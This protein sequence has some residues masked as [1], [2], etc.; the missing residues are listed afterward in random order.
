VLPQYRL[1]AGGAARPGARSADQGRPPCAV[2]HLRGATPTSAMG[3]RPRTEA[4]A[5]AR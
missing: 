2:H 5:A 3:R 4:G 1:Y